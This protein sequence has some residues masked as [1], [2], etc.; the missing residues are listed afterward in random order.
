MFRTYHRDSFSVQID[1]SLFLP[2]SEVTAEMPFETSDAR[3]QRRLRFLIT[4]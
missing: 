1:S 2:A 3:N 4:L